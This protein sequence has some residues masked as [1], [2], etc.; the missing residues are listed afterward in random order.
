MGSGVGVLTPDRRGER[1]SPP[2][3][4]PRGGRQRQG[5]EALIDQG[6]F[7]G[8]G[9]GPTSNGNDKA[10]RRAENRDRNPAKLQD[11]QQGADERSHEHAR[12]VD[13]D[14]VG[15]R[16]MAAE[17]RPA[18]LERNP[19]TSGRTRPRRSNWRTRAA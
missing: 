7:E 9:G 13:N 6:S 10:A 16:A 11:E 5:I 14:A 17:L 19:I 12:F 18:R 1:G 15:G 3:A 2:C 8:E 4:R